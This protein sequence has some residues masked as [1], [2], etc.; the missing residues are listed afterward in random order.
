MTRTNRLGIFIFRRDLRVKDNTGLYAFSK[1]YDIILPIFILDPH[2]AQLHSTNKHYFSYNALQFMLESLDSLNKQ[3]HK[4]HSQ[5][6]VFTN[7]PLTALANI[8]DDVQSHYD[9]KAVAWNHDS[10]TRYAQLRD[11]SIERMCHETYKLDVRVYEGDFTLLGEET[12]SGYKQF[13]AFY[14]NAVSSTIKYPISIKPTNCVK[15]LTLRHAEKENDIASLLHRYIPTYNHHIAVKG[16]RENAV[17]I[18]RKLK[19]NFSDYAITRNSLSHSTTQLSAY[20]NFGCVSVR[21]VYHA[22]CL[23]KMDT[24]FIK[25]LYWRDFFFQIAMNTKEAASFSHHIDPR[26]EKIH[27]R[28]ANDKIGR[29]EWKRLVTG[30]TG[31]LLID[32]GIN[33]MKVTGFMHNRTRMLV[34]MFWTKYLRFHILDKK[35]GS[36]VGFSRYLVDAVGPSQNKMNHHWLTELDFPGRKFS[37]K[38]VPLSG[39]PMDVSNRMIRKWDPTGVYVKKW[40]PNLS[41]VDMIDL[42]KWNNEISNKY[43]HVHPPPMFDAK[44]RYKEWIQACRF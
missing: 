25:Q 19:S 3:L 39:R 33:E 41:R 34:G 8:I 15:N 27:W 24:D 17:R 26:F 20:L 38:G 4:L 22:S 6:Y 31:F 29:K 11:K 32:A 2:Q 40:L 28:N 13:G 42:Y 37:S 43:S 16:G 44:T 7:N 23:Q 1:D 21:E 36:Q 9:V 12:P 5:L 35:W 18:I 14:R 30:T 10:N